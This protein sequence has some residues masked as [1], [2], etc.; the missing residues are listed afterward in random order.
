MAEV[1]DLKNYIRRTLGESSSNVINAPVD[2]MGL[3]RLQLMKF[4]RNGVSFEEA[5]AE[6]S[7]QFDARVD[8]LNALLP[9]EEQNDPDSL[10]TNMNQA[11]GEVFGDLVF[12]LE[13]LT[14]QLSL[15]LEGLRVRVTNLE[16]PGGGGGL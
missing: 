4:N 15:M 13:D 8:E 11:M 7:E 1:P 14:R 9:E 3:G 2:F 16:N 6:R 12:S 5:Y 10:A